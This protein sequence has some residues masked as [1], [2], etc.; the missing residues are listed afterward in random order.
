MRTQQQ[1]LKHGDVT[2]AIVRA[3]YDVYNELG[4]GFLESVYREAMTQVLRSQGHQVEQER[5][6]E[7]YFRGASVGSYRTDLVIDDRVIVELKCARTLESAHEAQL[8]NYLKATEF[9]VGLLPNFGHKPQ[10]KRM[11][12]DVLKRIRANR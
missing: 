4:F 9:D 2:F 8:L 11:I 5:S 3:F 1:Q 12:F 10:F 6:V 7:V